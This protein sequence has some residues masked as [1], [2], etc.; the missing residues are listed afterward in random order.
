MC[1]CCFIQITLWHT[2]TKKGGKSILDFPFVDKIVPSHFLMLIDKPCKWAA[3]FRGN[4]NEN[5]EKSKS[6]TI[7]RN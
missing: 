4:V 1:V 3:K 2:D 6:T 5:V 7:C